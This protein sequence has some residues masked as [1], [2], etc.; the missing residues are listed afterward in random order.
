MQELVK[1]QTSLNA[2]KDKK[3]TFAN[4]VY[5]SAESILEALKPHLKEHNCTVVLTDEIVLV[6]DR[7]YIKATATLT[8]GKG[9]QVSACGYAREA[10]IKKGNDDAQITGAC[11]SYA[12]KYALCGLFAIDDSRVDPDND[13]NTQRGT[14]A[15]PSKRSRATAPAAPATPAPAKVKPL[16]QDGNELWGK[17]IEYCVSK[18][19]KAESLRKFYTISDADIVKLQEIV[20]F[21]RSFNKEQ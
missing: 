5:R 10:E 2:P 16:V 6:G 13:D 7:F 20:D 21:Q 18:G 12:R 9:E 4:Y 3:N 19:V 17:A 15:N 14:D 8:N 1:I 11:S